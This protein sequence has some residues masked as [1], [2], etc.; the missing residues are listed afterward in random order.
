MDGCVVAGYLEKDHFFGAIADRLMRG[1]MIDRGLFPAVHNAR[2]LAP[3][4]FQTDLACARRCSRPR[5]QTAI[6]RAAEVAVTRDLFAVILDRIV[7]LAIP[8][9][10]TSGCVT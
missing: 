2:R 8:P 6:C 7:L 5:Q 3:L 1:G 9:P 4:R 10:R